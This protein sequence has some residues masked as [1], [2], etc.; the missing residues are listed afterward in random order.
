VSLQADGTSL[1]FPPATA[2]PITTTV[3]AG[4]PMVRTLSVVHTPSG[5]QLQILGLTDTRELTQ[6]SV[7]FQPAPGSS[8]NNS[9]LT[10]PLSDLAKGWFQSADSATFGGQFA[11]TMPFTFQGDVSLSSIS[12]VLSN[13]SGDSLPVSANY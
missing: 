13:G 1:D 8:L 5:V 11:L 6:A 4:P 9:Q 7:T 2:Q 10:V 3:A 12:V